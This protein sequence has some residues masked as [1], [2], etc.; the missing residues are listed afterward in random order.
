MSKDKRAKKSYEFA[1]ES[2]KSFCSAGSGHLVEIDDRKYPFCVKITPNPQLTVFADEDGEKDG[3]ELVVSVGLVT[4]VRSTLKFT[5]DS[6][7][8]KK[9]I[10]LAENLGHLYYHAYREE[11]DGDEEE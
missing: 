9:I 7:E 8:L 3:G 2:L 10:K 5:L 1:V 4:K 11:A 6:R